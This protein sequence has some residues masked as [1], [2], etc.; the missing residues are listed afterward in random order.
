MKKYSG[1]G[2]SLHVGQGVRACG[3]GGSGGGQEPG[4]NV[5]S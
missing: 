3:E 2:E 1:S 4:V 5:M